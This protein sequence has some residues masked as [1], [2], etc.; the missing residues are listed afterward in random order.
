[1]ILI[2]STLFA[3][4]FWRRDRGVAEAGFIIVLLAIYALA[5]KRSSY[6]IRAVGASCLLVCG[7]H[8]LSV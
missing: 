7:L 2:W 3:L 1:M 8:L 6:S 5:G 4:G